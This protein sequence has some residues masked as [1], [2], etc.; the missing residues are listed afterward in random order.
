MA[1]N[2]IV[3]LLIV[4]ITL[5]LATQG[6]LS[7]LLALATSIFASILAMGLLEP[8]KG[9]IG[10]WR[11]DYARGITFLVLYLAVFS[12]TRVGA[13]MAVPKSIKL[14]KLVNRVAGGVLGFFTGLVIVGTLLLGFEMLPI[15]RDFMG[16]DRFPGA[17]GM[18]AVDSDGRPVYGEVARPVNVWFA[19]DYFVQAIW[20]GASGRSL[21][22]STP[23]A[24]V[25]PDMPVECYGYRNQIDGSLRA[26]PQDLVKVTTVWIS[27]PSQIQAPWISD[28]K[29]R[30]ANSAEYP[31]VADKKLVMV[32]TEVGRGAQAPDISSDEDGYLRVTT[33]QVR[34]VTSKN[35]QYYPFGYL[36]TGQQFV[37][38]A[39][40]NGFIVD[41]YTRNGNTVEDWLFQVPEGETPTLIEMKQLGRVPL[42]GILKAAPTNPLARNEYPAHAYF[43]DLC[44]FS[45]TF[46]PGSGDVVLKEGRLY[47]LR[48]DATVS[49]VPR[50][51]LSDADR[52]N[53][54]CLS[55]ME[56]PANGWLPKGKPGVPG[57]TPFQ[58]AHSFGYNILA[59][60]G[61]AGV[62][63]GSVVPML[64]LGQT[65]PDGEA[66]LRTLPTYFD[67]DIVSIW[68]NTRK[69]SLITGFAKADE[70]GKA[71]VR[72]ISPGR[73]VVVVTMLTNR[74]FYVWVQDKDFAKGAN[75]SLKAG[76]KGTASEP[77]AF[78]I[79]LDVTP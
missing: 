7:A 29:L 41:D 58:T 13:D 74:G 11:P 48:P 27:D 20:N 17:S 71:E 14:P 67:N 25:H 31:L 21:G 75:S 79:D 40:N 45:A 66:N 35:R 5:Y 10:S 28:K 57:K 68:R 26:V 56:N 47:I 4:L 78:Q 59:D 32:R 65:Q 46:D 23:W 38:L 76:A 36:E 18:Q 37:P 22:G 9:I 62:A 16:F 42:A 19:P 2:I 51:A 70:A 49:D 55:N 73:H 44:T 30:D 64:L 34:L 15:S 33:T 6:M 24:S 61:D 1:L 3:F 52:H 12:V 77:T 63:W 43:K 54:E 69:G 60:S 72:K 8:L 53:L 39:L 50:T